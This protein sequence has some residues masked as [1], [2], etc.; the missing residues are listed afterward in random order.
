[1]MPWRRFL[2]LTLALFAL[3]SLA[4][5]G[6]ILVL[7]PYQNVPFSP[8]LPR[9]PVAQNQRYAYPALARQPQFDSAIVG[10]SMVRLLNPSRLNE[11]LGARFVNLAMNSATA[12]EQVQMNALFLRHHPRAKF[13]VYAIDDSWCRAAAATDRYTFRDFPEFMFDENRWNDLL[14]L[15]N[16]K[17]LE[18]AVRMLE[19]V[20]G[21]REPKYGADGYFD[22]TRDFGA[23]DLGRTRQRIY[24]SPTPPPAPPPLDLE[25]AA[26]TDAPA[27]ANLDL[28]PTLLTAAPP[29]ARIVLL[30]P[31]MHVW[32]QQQHAANYRECKARV[33]ETVA[34]MARVQV[35]D[36][37]LDSELTRRDENYWDAIHYGDGIAAG[38]ERDIAAALAG[39]FV[40]RQG[41]VRRGTR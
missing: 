6:F 39:R 24:G 32:H 8:A 30:M 36:Y 41:V 33:L 12:H 35:L 1:M 17:A 29:D 5:Y 31:P 14:Y 38:I 34:P 15:F 18:N 25:P 21:K 40:A 11:L 9:A 10:T 20:Q 27:M 2:G 4:C 22:F 19:L 3:F 26:S 7:D 13:L 28:L 16:D 37:L 23:Y